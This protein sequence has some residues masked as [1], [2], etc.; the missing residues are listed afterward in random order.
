MLLMFTVDSSKKLVVSFRIRFRRIL[1]FYRPILLFD[2][3]NDIIGEF[4]KKKSLKI[5]HLMD[6]FNKSKNFQKWIQYLI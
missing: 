1:E 4:W 2:E 3:S 6:P 5:N